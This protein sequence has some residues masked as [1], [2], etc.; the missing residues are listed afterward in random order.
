MIRVLVVGL[1]QMGLSHAMAYAKLPEFQVV[2]LV[3]RS[4]VALPEALGHLGIDRDFDAALARLKPDMVAIATYSD[5]HA[6][7]A[8]KAMEGARMCLLKNRW[9]PAWP[10]VRPW[11]TLPRALAAS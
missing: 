5:S 6:A 8:I 4:E 11:P 1:G 3:N 9:P 2:G 7:L 10:I